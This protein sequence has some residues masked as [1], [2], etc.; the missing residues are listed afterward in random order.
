MTRKTFRPI[1]AALALAAGL[2][3]A[4]PAQEAASSTAGFKE[5]WAYVMS[6]ELEHLRDDLPLTDVFYFAAGI[7]GKGELYGGSFGAK[8]AG[9]ANFR[10]HLVLAD[11][12]NSGLLHFV[13]APEFGL[14]DK[15]VADL[16]AR[17]K[18]YDG[19]Q[20]DFEAI[21]AYDKDNFV[22][23]LAKLKAAIGDK[24]LSVALP[25]RTK[26]TGD[27]FDYPAI[28]AVVDRALVMAYDHHWSGSAPGAIAGMDWS[29]AVAAYAL[30][31]IGPDKLVMGM[32]FYG[33]VWNDRNQA[34]SYRFKGIDKLLKENNLNPLRDAEGVPYF[35]FSATSTYTAYYEDQSSMAK[36]VGLYQA[37]GVQK[38]G[39]WRLGQE[40]PAVWRALRVQ[41]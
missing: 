26:A 35:S 15:L 22:Q 16:A 23:F 24:L 2:A 25:A 37:A 28:A 14:R 8:P 29:A 13:L 21:A 6:G 32:P 40:D 39:F 27:A 30:K 9:K 10:R 18:D 5:I 3:P 1:L 4:L 12:S 19:V 34:G 36:R 7:S 31:T 11:L 20:I 38:I 17:L 33:R 41:P